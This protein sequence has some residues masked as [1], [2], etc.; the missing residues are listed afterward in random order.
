MASPAAERIPVIIGVGEY[1]ER[2]ARPDDS[3]EP[4]DMMAKALRIANEDCGGAALTQLDKLNVIM[5]MSWKYS[6]LPGTLCETLNITPKQA[7]LGPSGG[8]LP[9]HYRHL[10]AM[11]QIGLKLL[12]R[13]IRSLWRWGFTC[14]SI[15]I[16]FS[17]PLQRPIG[18]KHQ[19]KLIMKQVRSYLAHPILP[20]LT[21]RA[22]APLDCRIL[23]YSRL[24]PK[25]V[26]SRGPIL[27]L[28]WRA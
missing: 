20:R 24:P 9:L 5:P 18:G 13:Y 11:A 6:D 25:T 14:R 27:N 16:R 4:R 23:T 15:F 1:I 12:G 8:Q 7:K 26:S 19:S 21:L 28:W 17:K 22:G 10:Q 3:L 2:P